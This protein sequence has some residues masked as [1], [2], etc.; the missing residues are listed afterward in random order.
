MLPRIL[1]TSPQTRNGR[2][3]KAKRLIR[4]IFMAPNLQTSKNK[5]NHE[6]HA[7]LDG[8]KMKKIREYTLSIKGNPGI[9]TGIRTS[10]K[11]VCEL[12]RGI[13]CN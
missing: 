9:R 13:V 6:I 11:E 7:A 3:S 12:L 10:I 4:E 2:S 5:N 8:N 1:L